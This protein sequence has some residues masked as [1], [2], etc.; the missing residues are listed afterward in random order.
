MSVKKEIILTAVLLIGVA[1]VFIAYQC[2]ETFWHWFDS[3]IVIIALFTVIITKDRFLLHAVTWL[4]LACTINAWITSTFYDV[5]QFGM[6][7]QVFAFFISALIA[8]SS[9]TYCIY[10]FTVQIKLMDLQKQCAR[11][12]KNK[13][14]EVKM[15]INR[16]N[17]SVDTKLGNINESIKGFEEDGRA[18]KE[19]IKKL[20]NGF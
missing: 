18:L 11:D 9:L 15:Q 4:F 19:F 5:T 17:D 13:Y 16:L 8:S 20:E 6:N 2:G 3:G 10:R 7:Q 12:A 1:A 14:K